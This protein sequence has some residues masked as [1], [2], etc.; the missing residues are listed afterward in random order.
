MSRDLKGFPSYIY[1]RGECTYFTQVGRRS[2]LKD[3]RDNDI[4]DEIIED[5]EN[6]YD[7]GHLKIIISRQYESGDTE[8]CLRHLFKIY[9]VDG[10][11]LTLSY[12]FTT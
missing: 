7:Q 4:D 1:I 10:Y 8:N 9:T 11:V 5:I 6:L 3:F 12:D 2:N